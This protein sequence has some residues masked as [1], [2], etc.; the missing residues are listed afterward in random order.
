MLIGAIDQGTTAT[1]AILTSEDGIERTLPGMQHAQIFPHSGW[2]EHDPLELLAHVKA[3]AEELVAAGAEALCLANQGETVVAWDRRTGV[4]LYNAIVWNDARTGE[5]IGRLK[6]AGFEQQ[7]L[8]LTGLPLDP[9]FSASKL[10]WILANVEGATSLAASGQLGIGTSDSFLLDRL[11]G[12]YV[13]DATTAARTA[14]AD[15]STLQWNSELGDRFGVPIDLLPRI[16]ADNEPIGEV[17]TDHGPIPLIASVVDQVAALYGHGA[18]RVGEG[19]ITA[20]T[21]AFVLTISSFGRPLPLESRAIRAAAWQTGQGRAFATEG[22]VYSAAACVEW[23]TRIGLLSDV[24][25]IDALSGDPAAASDLFFVPALSGLA[26]PHWDRSAA[27]L[28]IGMSDSTDRHSMIK[29]VLEGVAFRIADALQETQRPARLGVAQSIDG[30]LSRARY[31][32]QFLADIAQ[33]EL[34]AKTDEELTAFGAAE[35]GRA[36]YFNIDP[37]D[38]HPRLSRSNQY[39]PSL[40]GTTAT[41]LR[42]RFNDALQR[43]TGWRQ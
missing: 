22:A 43:A 16:A 8:E 19:K 13:T 28:F 32:V 12:E 36:R 7:L 42:A 17:L 37:T 39:L 9:Y 35:L 27:G 31:F 18:R 14:L 11:T 23:V 34:H 2:V 4:P 26:C 1:K 40:P 41:E 25:E 20:G 33:V 38:H 15:I 24:S 10:H 6:T 5:Q 29:A 30:G 3:K 21:G